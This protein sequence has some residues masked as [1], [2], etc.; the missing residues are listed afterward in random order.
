MGCRKKIKDSYYLIF[1][2]FFFFINHTI[3]YYVE[4]EP[5]YTCNFNNKNKCINSG[6]FLCGKLQ[7]SHFVPCFHYLVG[8]IGYLHWKAQLTRLLIGMQCF[9]IDTFGI[10]RFGYSFLI[11]MSME[12][13]I[14]FIYFSGKGHIE[15]KLVLIFNF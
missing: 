12:C 11:H 7:L 3:Y 14:F 9:F 4:L 8:L 2:F 10:Y 1:F 15:L 13:S 5:H 6:A